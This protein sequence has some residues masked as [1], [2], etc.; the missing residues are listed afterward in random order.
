MRTNQLRWVLLFLLIAVLRLPAQQSEADRKLM[1]EMRAKAE[2]GDARSQ[3]ELGAALSR[4]DF[5]VRRTIEAAKWYRK[6]AEQN[7]AEAQ[8]NLGLCYAKGEGVAQ[9][10][11]ET[12]KWLTLSATQ[13]NKNAKKITQRMGESDIQQRS[14]RFQ[15]RPNFTRPRRIRPCSHD[16]GRTDCATTSAITVGLRC[17]TNATSF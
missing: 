6:A 3:F 12:L 11:A 14:P 10:N 15:K 8:F 13:G 2:K 16:I 9:D 7:D 1:S 17:E 5:G 4:G